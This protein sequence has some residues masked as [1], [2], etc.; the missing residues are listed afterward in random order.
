MKRTPCCLRSFGNQVNVVALIC[1]VELF[2]GLNVL[3]AEPPDVSY[4]FPAG[5]RVGTEV[6]F[7][8]GGHYLHEAADFEMQGKGVKAPSRIVR[9]QTTWFEGP[10]IPQPA[11][12]QRENY[13]KDYA[14]NVT[15]AEDAELGLRYWRV[16][17][18][19]GLTKW[20]P[21]V[22]G[23]LPEVLEEE[24]DGAPVPVRVDFPVTINGRIFPREDI[25]IWTIAAQ[26]GDTLTCEVVAARIGS[27]LDSRLEILDPAGQRLVEN[28]DAIGTD[29][30]VQF[31]A[32]Q[33]GVY[34]I[35]IH[36]VN[37]GG[38]Q[39][40][41]YRLTVTDAPYINAVYPLGGRRGENINMQVTGVNLPEAALD[42]TLP[43]KANKLYEHRFNI[44]G[45]LSNPVRLAIDDLPE[46]LEETAVDDIITLPAVFNGRIQ[47]P[48]EVDE[49]QISA[50]QGSCW[51]FDVQAAE[52]G[53]PLD[54]VLRILDATGKELGRSDDRV[55][56]QTDSQLTFT[57]PA[58]GTYT[59]RIADRLASRGGPLYAY[60]LRATP[61]TDDQQAPEF[62]V[63][64]PT[65]VIN[66]PRGGEVKLK[67]DVARHNGFSAPIEID[68]G[69]LPAGVSVKGTTVA[70]NRKN[71]QLVFSADDSVSVQTAELK[72][73]ASAK[74]KPT[75]KAAGK[76]QAVDTIRTSHPVE[77]ESVR[78]G[79]A[80]TLAVVIPTPFQFSGTFESR[81]APRGS[82]FTRHY[83]LDRGGFNGPIEISLADKQ[84]RHLQGVTGPTIIVP[85][86]KSEF[87]FPIT[88][89][90][91]LVVGRT[92]RT[93]LMAVGTVTEADGSEHKVAYT[94]VQQ[95]DQMIVLTDPNRLSVKLQRDSIAAKAGGQIQ[96]PVMIDKGTGLA[97]EVTVELR[98]PQHC[99]GVTS[100]P[101]VVAANA[102]TA[103]LTIE[104]A[105][106]SLGP[107]NQP[108][109]IRATMNDERGLP[110]VSETRLTIVPVR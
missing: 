37:F 5:G 76:D 22:V 82:V 40:Y 58:D 12:Q 28:V 19:Q 71:A 27:G 6:T 52:L 26:A 30:R 64:F 24:I 62:A 4:I 101:M 69:P 41:V 43:K 109:T 79:N 56:G 86:N 34:Q 74:L 45:Q 100:S 15:I 72:M 13:P 102:T 33:D 106:G 55:G 31:T 36:D 21:F 44:N 47:Q 57:I 93:T 104:F 98:T 96:L 85:P 18:S 8:V 10:V 48:G 87:E 16:H 11:S 90:P 46:Y 67:V 54:S 66:L 70:K 3:M 83:S 99:R 53:S 68:V 65:E 39:H 23:D 73:Q 77:V 80:I 51:S 89:P 88:L 42:V 103:V 59:V 60:R 49:W 78:D 14:G 7:H 105:D 97:G 61:A 95:A 50:Q 63:T 94:S 107:F 84:V 20:L 81:Y 92:S 32:P 9:T 38:L 110:V 1:A 35:R 25:D 91:W 17:T 29:S 75:K 108:A 2:C